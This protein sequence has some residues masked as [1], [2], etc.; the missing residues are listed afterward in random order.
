MSQTTQTVKQFI[1]EEFLPGEDPSALT[2]E[3]PLF[4][5]GLLDSIASLKLVSFLEQEFGITV[6]PHDIVA[7]NLDTLT[8][9]EGFVASK[10]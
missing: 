7:D 10:R 9:I 5:S 2:E 1:L 4:T 8:A 3:T 6:A